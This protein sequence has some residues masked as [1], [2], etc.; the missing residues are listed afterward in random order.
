M[1]AIG[2]AGGLGS[3]IPETG[4]NLTDVRA[5]EQEHAQTGLAN[6]AANLHDKS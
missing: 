4:L 2:R 6:A 1:D 3:V 5:G